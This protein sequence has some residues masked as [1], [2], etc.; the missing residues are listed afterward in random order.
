MANLSIRS[1]IANLFQIGIE[2]SIT[3]KAF[4][5]D[6]GIFA[7]YW[8]IFATYQIEIRQAN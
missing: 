6:W 5:K 3:E 1:N 7:T 2:K 4:Y 8:I